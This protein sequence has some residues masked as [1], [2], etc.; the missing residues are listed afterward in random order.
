[1]ARRRRRTRKRFTQKIIK[2][3]K[4]LIIIIITIPERR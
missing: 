3:K 1:L 4:N 2:I